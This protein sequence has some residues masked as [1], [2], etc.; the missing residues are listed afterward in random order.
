MAIGLALLGLLNCVPGFAH[1]GHDPP[2]YELD[3][4]QAPK[5]VLPWGILAKAGVTHRD[6][7]LSVNFL[8]PVQ[9]LDG[10]RVTLYGFMT[11]VYKQDRHRTFLLS[12]RPLTCVGCTVPPRPEGIVEVSVKRPEP[13]R[14][15]PI[16]VR[17]RLELV[18]DA[19][20][21]PIYRLRDASV[22]TRTR[23]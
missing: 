1:E 8:P 18:K 7:K 3:F 14:D 23:Q 5:G 4:S 17:G 13:A 15:R 9:A 2:E 11:P 12:M 6:G 20:N 21:G 16:A 10:K 22:V 19:A